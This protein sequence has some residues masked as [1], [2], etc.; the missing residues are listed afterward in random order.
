MRMVVAGVVAVTMV[1][2]LGGCVAE[3]RI[4]EYQA[5]AEALAERLGAEVPEE[6]IMGDAIVTSSIGSASPMASSSVWWDVDR[7][8]NLVDEPGAS[9]RAA[10]AVMAVLDDEGWRRRRENDNASGLGRIVD[11]F[12]KDGW[13]VTVSWLKTREG[14][15]ETV[16]IWVTSPTTSRGDH[17]VP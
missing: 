12:W 6:L 13:Y 5:E 4:D 9:E 7:G 17:R 8:Y 16:D 1:L 15:A 10:A 11:A 2:S 14:R 3:S